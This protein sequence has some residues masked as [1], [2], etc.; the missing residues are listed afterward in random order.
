MTHWTP[1]DANLWTATAPL[2]K[3][4]IE[5]RCTVVRLGD[6]RL[7]I[8]SAIWMEE[9]GMAE[10]ETLGE[11][12]VLLVPGRF[13]RLDAARYKERYPDLRVLCPRGARPFVEKVVPVDG[14]Y[15]QFE[16]GGRVELLSPPGIQQAEGVMLV[17]DQ[18]GVSLVFNDLLF[19]QPHE[20]GIGGLMMRMIGSSG[21]PKV[22]PL[23]RMLMVKDRSALAGWMR[24]TA[25]TPNLVRM[26]P[27]HGDLIDE[28]AAGVL[29]AVADR[30]A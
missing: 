26:I 20:N 19:N 30:V 10:L 27:G 16:T 9:E 24:E 2:P 21:G 29:K 23:A 12:G 25:E 22:T 15:S 3:Q 1:I 4:V 13:H 18:G 17:R 8:H 5:R 11:P 7:V 6:G 14:T 28:D